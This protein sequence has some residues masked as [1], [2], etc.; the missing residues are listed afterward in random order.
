MVPAHQRIAS[1]SDMVLPYIWV[2]SRMKKAG[3]GVG[4]AG[5]AKDG[6]ASEALVG[7][8][9]QVAAS[10]CHQKCGSPFPTVQLIPVSGPI[11]GLQLERVS[12]GDAAHLG[13]GYTRPAAQVAI[14]GS[15]GVL[16]A[17]GLASGV[18][19]RRRRTSAAARA[20]RRSAHR[21]GTPQSMF[22][23]AA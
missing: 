20:A 5:G 15:N 13:E 7:V 19:V 21:P 14:S 1:A 11:L 18:R 2:K 12:C 23:T 8:D 3:V 4:V 16:P 17:S 10:V 9:R 22:P 6:A